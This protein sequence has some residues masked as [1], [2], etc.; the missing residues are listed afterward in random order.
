[1]QFIYE[2]ISLKEGQNEEM[3]NEDRKNKNELLKLSKEL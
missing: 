1:M 3:I 2:K